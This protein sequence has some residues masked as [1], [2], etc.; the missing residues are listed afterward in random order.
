[1]GGAATLDGRRFVNRHIN[2]PKIDCNGGGAL[3]MGRDRGGMRGVDYFLLFWAGEWGNQRE[4][5]REAG[6]SALSGRP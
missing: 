3:L 1:M 4:R 5:E 2:Q 6:T